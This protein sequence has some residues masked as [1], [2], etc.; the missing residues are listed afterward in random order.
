MSKRPIVHFRDDEYATLS[1]AAEHFT[2]RLGPFCGYLLEGKRRKTIVP[3][4]NR[5]LAGKLGAS[6]GNLTQMLTHL[7]A[8][9]QRAQTPEEAK[10]IDDLVDLVAQAHEALFRMEDA[11]TTTGD[12]RMA[13]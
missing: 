5:S 9:A 4:F 1:R 13:S 8:A 6:H 10:A 7:S 11:L 3:A 12:A 2:V